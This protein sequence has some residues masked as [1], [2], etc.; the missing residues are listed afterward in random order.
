MKNK[1][2]EI[3]L[4]YGKLLS[5]LNLGKPATVFHSGGLTRTSPVRSIMRM[6]KTNVVFR[7]ENSVYCVTPHLRP[8][9]WAQPAAAS[10]A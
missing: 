4:L 2:N 9:M 5:P 6:S 1:Q 3:R 10:A 8:D 7:T